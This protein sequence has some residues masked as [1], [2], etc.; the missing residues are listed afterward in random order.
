MAHKKQDC[1]KNKVLAKVLSR[2]LLH[3]SVAW[4]TMGG[5][6]EFLH[7]R[8]IYVERNRND[9]NSSEAERRRRAP[10][11]LPAGFRSDRRRLAHRVRAVHEEVLRSGSGGA[12]ARLVGGRGRRRAARPTQ[13][14]ARRARRRRAFSA[15]LRGRGAA[16]P[17]RAP[18]DGRPD[19]DAG[20]AL[21]AAAQPL[22]EAAA[23]P[24]RQRRSALRPQR[25]TSGKGSFRGVCLRD[26]VSL[27]SF[28]TAQ[29]ACLRPPSDGMFV[30]GHRC[31]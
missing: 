16:P 2:M 3:S 9:R 31:R 21:P 23:N 19:L 5:K 11:L 20:R 25:R 4:I 1:R 14:R 12:A 7:G 28:E 8:C 18:V 17:C 27:R 15:D 13:R 10:L 22:G 24:V 26:H 6:E 29:D 30:R